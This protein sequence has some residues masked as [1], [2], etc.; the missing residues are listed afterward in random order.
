MSD[1]SRKLVKQHDADDKSALT[2][3]RQMKIDLEKAMRVIRSS[4]D[5]S[6]VYPKRASWWF[7]DGI[8]TALERNSNYTSMEYQALWTQVS[9]ADGDSWTFS[10]V[11]AAGSY[12]FYTFG[13]KGTNYGI[14]DYYL[15]GES[16]ETGQDWYGSYTNNVTKSFTF[17][18]PSSGYHVFTLTVNGKNGSSSDYRA[19]L[20]RLYILPTAD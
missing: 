15:D 12:T 8:G 6:D 11:L 2:E 16:I 5:A 14:L 13:R 18:V 19:V 4:P 10:A 1:K 9:P 20:T 7:V 3:L 17:S